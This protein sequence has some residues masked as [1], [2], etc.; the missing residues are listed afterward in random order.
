MLNNIQ[1]IAKLTLIT[2]MINIKNNS[3]NV[4]S[5]TNNYVGTYCQKNKKIINYYLM[6]IFKLNKKPRKKN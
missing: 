5:I 2:L 1:I 4:Y 6:E 3:H